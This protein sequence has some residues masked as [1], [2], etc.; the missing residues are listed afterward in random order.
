[1]KSK[2][3]HVVTSSTSA[4]NPWGSWLK[5]WLPVVVMTSVIFSL[6]SIPAKALPKV[7]LFAAQDKLIH[8]SEYGL[9]G[10]FITR[11]LVRRR[12]RRA[13]ALPASPSEATTSPVPMALVC[14][15]A[16]LAL[17]YGLSDEFHQSFV[18]GRSVEVL[19]M[20]ADLTGGFLGG[21]V[22]RAWRRRVR[23]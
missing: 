6:S 11:A 21:L 3:L 13:A 2:N 7:H 20:T 12:A 16:G 19:D 18:P 4:H 5:S 15:A 23:R 8:T 14:A 22:Y 9:L 10:L 17:A 1:M